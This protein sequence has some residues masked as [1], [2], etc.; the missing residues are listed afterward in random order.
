MEKSKEPIRLRR[1]LLPTGNTSLYLDIYLSGKRSYEYLHL[2][3]I[4]EKTR[5]DKETNRETLKLADAIRAKRVVELRNGAFGFAEAQKLDTNFL[6]YFRTLCEKRRQNSESQGNWGNWCGT[7][8]YLE[9]YCN[10]GTTFRDTTPQW[11]QGFKDYLD[12]ADVKPGSKSPGGSATA[13]KLAPGTKESYFTKLRACFN[14]AV[15][16]GI[17]MQNPMHGIVNFKAEEHE[18]V[19]LTLEE[20]KAMAATECKS[21]AL[22][23]AFMFSCLT[24]LRKS[25][26][27]KMTWAEVRQEGAFTRIVF[28]QKKTGGQEYIDIN[29]Q[30]VEYMGQR[31]NPTDRVF[32][33]FAYS[34]YSQTLLKRWAAAAG[35]EKSV[36]FHSGRHTFA[37]LMLDL[38]ADI[39]TVQKLLG[40]RTIN[41][42]MIYAKVMDKK[43]QEAAM[44]IPPILPKTDEKE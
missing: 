18:R 40:H 9:G 16:E 26:I 17:I 42:T 36:T 20:V 8:K 6:A 1:R 2:Y 28:R 3:L 39:Y 37:V 10:P 41:T 35:I 11:V 29:P 25:D 44:L 27:E 43:K 12:K 32:E 14:Q 4:P 15:E 33:G 24:G 22:K 38:G 13:A 30:A 21:Q 19:Y 31:R 34:G 7:L 23:R 5:A